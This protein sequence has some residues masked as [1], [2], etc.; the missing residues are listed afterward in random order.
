[1]T[2]GGWERLTEKDSWVGRLKPEVLQGWQ[3][4][5]ETF[6]NGL[7]FFRV[8]YSPP[9][10][11]KVKS[12]C[13]QPMPDCGLTCGHLVLNSGCTQIPDTCQRFAISN[14]IAP[15]EKAHSNNAGFH[16]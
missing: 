15:R 6:W 7:V 10:S 9:N 8:D 4:S 3:E 16:V 12:E 2:R 13:E 14:I 5:V 11:V 1:M